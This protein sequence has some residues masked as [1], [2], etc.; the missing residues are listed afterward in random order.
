MII[1]GKVCVS[2]CSFLLVGDESLLLL[3]GLGFGGWGCCG[4]TVGG[5]FVI[6]GPVWKGIVWGVCMDRG[7]Q[8]SGGPR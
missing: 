6:S 4:R 8:V 1:S 3:R 5:C 2:A 7:V